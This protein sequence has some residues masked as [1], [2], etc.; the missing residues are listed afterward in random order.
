MTNDELI[1]AWRRKLPNVEPTERELS[2][3]ALG[4]ETGAALAAEQPNVVDRL[5]AKGYATPPG[6]GVDPSIC[7]A[8]DQPAA[9]EQPLCVPRHGKYL[10]WWPIRSAPAEQPQPVAW[11][12]DFNGHADIDYTYHFR[13]GAESAA[14]FLR[15][16]KAELGPFTVV[17]LYAAPPPRPPAP[18]EQPVAVRVLDDDARIALNAALC[19]FARRWAL[20]GDWLTCKACA[21]SLI[22]SRV[23][24][25]LRHDEGCKLAATTEPRP[26]QALLTIMRPLYVHSPPPPAAE[27]SEVTDAERYRFVRT[28]DRVAISPQAARDPV[29]YDAAIDAAIAA[30]KARNT[31]PA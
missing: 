24:E 2:A 19:D 17:P 13:D 23:N 20:D 3:F 31:N 26:W 11:T 9:A 22:A 7:S 5:R 27:P 18:A 4:V 30:A 29:A 16:H 14:E 28:A 25:T 8:S 12:V 15:A 1:A 6:G 21:R 10:R